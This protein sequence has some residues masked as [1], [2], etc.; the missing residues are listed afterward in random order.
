MATWSPH[1]PGFSGPCGSDLI[2]L[3]YSC[4]PRHKNTLSYRVVNR[5]LLNCWHIAL[6][7]PALTWVYVLRKC[8]R[9]ELEESWPLTLIGPRVVSI[10]YKNRQFRYKNRQFPVATPTHRFCFFFHMGI[11]FHPGWLPLPSAAAG[12]E[13]RGHLGEV[14]QV[15]QL[16]AKSRLL[17]L[18]QKPLS[19][20]LWKI[21]SSLWFSPD[22]L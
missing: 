20:C 19:L 8:W 4:V 11:W 18:V 10:R 5:Y 14:I 22:P 13:F 21:A 3:I 1:L 2:G 12:R 15:Q 9:R 7:P 17:V 16:R 6:G